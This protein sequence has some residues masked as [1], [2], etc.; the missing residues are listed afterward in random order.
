MT[1]PVG[2]ITVVYYLFT[3]A[4]QLQEWLQIKIVYVHDKN[5]N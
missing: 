1:L 3:E 5:I 2:E 4:L